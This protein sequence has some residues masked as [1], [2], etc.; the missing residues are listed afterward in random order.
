MRLGVL[1]VGLVI[2]IIVG[3]GIGY[4]VAPPK[5]MT[6]TVTTTSPVTTTVEQTVT[7]TETLIRTTTQTVTQT[8]TQTVTQTVA[9]ITPTGQ[10][11]LSLKPVYINSVFINGTL[12][13]ALYAPPLLIII[14]PG[15]YVKINNT[16][17]KAYNFTA[18]IYPPPSIPPP[19]SSTPVFTFAYFV[20]GYSGANALFIDEG[21]RPK[22]LITVAT[23]PRTWTSWAYVGYSYYS[24]LTISGGRYAFKNKWVEA[25]GRIVNLQ[26]VRPIAWVFTT[27]ELAASGQRT[28]ILRGV[29]P[30]LVPI[31]AATVYIT[32]ETGGAAALGNLLV[33]IQPGT[34]LKQGDMLLSQ[35]NFTLVYYA[36]VNITGVKSA[37]PISAFSFAFN[38]RID[39]ALSLVNKDGRPMPAITVALIPPEVTSWTWTPQAPARYDEVLR[40]GTYRFPNNWIRAGPYAIN[41]QFFRP[42][43][44]VFLANITTPSATFTTPP[45]T[46]ITIYAYDNYFVPDRITIPENSTIRFIVINRGRALHTFDINELG[47]HSGPIRPGDVWISPP[48]IITKTGRF[49]YYCQYHYLYGME[50][51]LE[52]G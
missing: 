15:T 52:V 1:I 44:W 19:D 4:L 34:Y 13:G 30:G 23:A 38:G 22:P 46:N 39:P 28:E 41:L 50:G 31:S 10:Q 42:V 40:G 37:L 7:R 17:Y 27:G 48:V 3:I 45:I 21:G 5:T 36:A 33:I 9:P 25:S 2:G 8:I 12:G 51:T 24:N 32:N 35:F 29:G 11:V 47:I 20:N 49:E 26:F 43:V 16:V 18:A 6:T 14:P